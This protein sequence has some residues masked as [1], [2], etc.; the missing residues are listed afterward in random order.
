MEG[1]DS[2][3][4][5]GQSVGAESYETETPQNNIGGTG[6]NLVSTPSADTTTEVNAGGAAAAT[7]L[8]GTPAGFNTWNTPTDPKAIDNVISNLRLD[9]PG[10]TDAVITKVY[11]QDVHSDL[12]TTLARAAGFSNDDARR[13]GQANQGVD[14]NPATSPFKSVETRRDF[15]FTTPERREALWQNFKQSGNLNDLGTFLHAQQDSYSH[16]GYGPKTGHWTHAPDKTYNDIPK[17]DRMAQDTFTRLVEARNF[18]DGQGRLEQGS[19]PIAYSEIRGLV[20]QFNS[21]TT[22]AQKS[23]LIQQI[24]RRITGADKI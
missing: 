24:Q 3:S 12:T 8:A 10:A 4:G 9:G 15:H 18:L 5:A 14:D 7:G 17:A 16:D 19:K 13:I 22:E 11:E 2:V 1:L 20:T 21:A 23:N 6:D